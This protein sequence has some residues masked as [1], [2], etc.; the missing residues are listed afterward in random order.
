MSIE[1][2]DESLTSPS[3]NKTDVEL[4]RKYLIKKLE[5]QSR[6]NKRVLYSILLLQ[7][8]TGL[9]FIFIVLY[10]EL[11]TLRTILFVGAG[12]LF[13]TTILSV[14]KVQLENIHLKLIKKTLATNKDL[15]DKITKE[16]LHNVNH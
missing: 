3:K 11:D 9:F 12:I 8:I 10:I 4:E 14:I 1:N 16:V 5:E 6:F 7:L 15:V 13:L 2:K